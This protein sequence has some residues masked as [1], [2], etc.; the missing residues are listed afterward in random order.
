MSSGEKS[1]HP[2]AFSFQ[3][4][5]AA[6]LPG[7]AASAANRL[8]RWAI[9]VLIL[10][11]I[12][13]GLF[14]RVPWRGDDLINTALAHATLESFF[15]HGNW[16]VLLLPLA[17]DAPWTTQGPLWI[18]VLSIFM[19][20]VYLYAFI[21]QTPLAIHLMDD[22]AR[23]PLAISMAVGYMV[24]WK[25]ADR[26]A[27][28]R[29]AQPIDPLGVGPKSDDFGKT[30]GDCAVLLAISALG[31][32][33]PWHQS[34][35]AAVGFLLQGLLLWSLAT[36]PETPKRA[37]GQ[38]AVIIV[39]T[40][41]THGLGL[42][43]AHLIT[44]L[45]V[46]RWIAPFRLVSRE[47]IGRFITVTLIL[48]TIWLIAT[49]VAL[50]ISQVSQWWAF[51]LS[52]WW[53]LKLLS[54]DL[55]AFSTVYA[56]LK[57]SLWRWWPLWPIALYG[58]WRARHL[59]WRK[60]PHWSVPLVSVVS[61]VGL[62]ILGPFEWKFQQLIPVIPLCLIAAYSLL[63]LPRPLVNLVD[64][65]AVVL[66]TLLAVVI[67]L[68]WIALNFG[69]PQAA[70]T[71]IATLT[72]GL[73]GNANLY[74]VAFGVI[75]TIGWIALVV[76]RV[77][78][79]EPRLWRPVVLSAG[80]LTLTWVLLMTLWLPAI[81]RLQG[82]Q[83]IAKALEDAWVKAAADQ[84]QVKPSTVR[85]EQSLVTR[86][87]NSPY[88]ITLSGQSP[89]LDALAIA[90]TRLPV[91]QSKD[92]HWRLAANPGRTARQDWTIIWQSSVEERRRRDRFVLFEKTSK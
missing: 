90:M 70:A 81:D 22:I 11:Y 68:Y 83:A 28:R 59:Q 73:I 71:R 25:A 69:V 7:L 56:W 24:I 48:V 75:A 21:T 57:E 29:E 62:G 26:F 58:L 80:G 46:F 13:H 91:S 49:L 87:V 51:G 12:S 40:L 84:R 14:D 64:W 44:V 18:L 1:S 41:L 78:R 9:A 89:S 4:A 77:G 60:A 20:P 30:L 74:E 47:F 17:P 19:A 23:I 31:I 6:P 32:V 55:S 88:C 33:V 61:L 82:Q 8:P 79:G 39:A 65:F 86:S 34:G 52:D 35:P 15:L 66:F 67:W 2:A 85:A 92:C 3:G 76:W 38:L 50:P 45:A 27:R 43:I 5:Q 16:S 72:P 42:A 36:A 10:L 63:S 54:G 37:A 53:L